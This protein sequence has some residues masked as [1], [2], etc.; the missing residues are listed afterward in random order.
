M[1]VSTRASI[2][3]VNDRIARVLCGCQD[4]DGGRLGRRRLK[5]N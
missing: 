1:C 3:M 2:F 5:I 4:D